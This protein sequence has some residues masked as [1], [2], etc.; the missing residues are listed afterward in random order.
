VNFLAPSEHQILVFLVQIALLLG[1]A[2]LLGQLSRRIGQPP[3]VGELVAGVLLGPSVLGQAAP[4]LFSWIFPS[5]AVQSGMLFT[6]GWLGVMLLL[7]NTGF[8]TDLTLIRRLGRAAALVTLGSL[9]LPFVFGLGSGFLAPSE[10]IGN[11]TQRVTF[12]L[13]LATALTIS[14]LPVIAKIL[15]ELGLVRR[16]FGQL[17]LAVGMAND[18]VGWVLLGLIAG[19]ASSGR[20]DVERLLWTVAALTVFLVAA[21]AVGQRIVDFAMRSMRRLRVGIGGFVTFAVVFAL[22]LGSITQAIGVEA[23]LGAFIAGILLGRSRYARWEAEDRLET[24]TTAVVAPI[25]F[26]TAGLRVDLGALT[27]SVVI[28]WTIVIVIVASVAK[29]AG[30]WAGARLAGL[31]NRDGM[32]LGAALN[33]RGALEIIIATVGLSIGVLNDSSY[34]IVVIM[35]IATSMMASPLLRAITRN[36]P[37]SPDEV[38][39]LQREER[40]AGN[41]FL[42]PSRSLMIADGGPGAAFAAQ[43][44]DAALPDECPVT[45]LR[46]TPDPNL[47]LDVMRALQQRNLELAA[48]NGEVESGVRQQLA[49]GYGTAIAAT[50]ATTCEEFSLELRTLLLEPDL[51]VIL[52]RPSRSQRPAPSRLL[53]PLSTSLPARAATELAVAVAADLELQLDVLHVRSDVDVAD[54][55]AGRLR[56]AG[57]RGTADPVAQQMLASVSDNAGEAGVWPRRIVVSYAS[58]AAGILE[59]SRRRRSDLVVI[60]VE[61]KDV[62]GTVHLGQ[63]ATQLLADPDLG[64]LVVA[65][66]PR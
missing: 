31:T 50:P 30:S 52:V 56:R 43:I 1:T 46:T 65:L 23:V 45:I 36:W 21:A 6:V 60:G 62:G 66:G 11:D 42:R 20:F 51:P 57:L 10:L 41:V 7:V 37:G 33:A 9:T 28:W 18:V 35:A 55:A 13:F 3:V 47:V 34:T 61:V 27:S 39:R 19:L 17:T 48:T 44:A 58:R 32:A 12:A 53:L 8:E 63:T 16:N 26:A 4:D 5:D 15:T 54:A 24:I 64:L 22:T 59:V 14:S 25:F 38:I 40:L 49:L 29:F 2:R